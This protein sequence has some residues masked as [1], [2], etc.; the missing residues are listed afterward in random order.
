MAIY[1]SGMPMHAGWLCSAPC[2]RYQSDQP[3]FRLSGSCFLFRTE[4]TVGD[5]D[6]YDANW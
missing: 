3:D 1:K 4:F 2:N 6:G 5:A